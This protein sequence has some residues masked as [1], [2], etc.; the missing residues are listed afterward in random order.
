MTSQNPDL[1]PP[2]RVEPSV[3]NLEEVY[4]RCG[5]ESLD[6]LELVIEDLMDDR[7]W[8]HY[9]DSDEFRKDLVAAYQD[10]Y[11]QESE[12]I[13][14]SNAMDAALKDA[15]YWLI[16]G[17]LQPGANI[18]DTVAPK[19]TGYIGAILPAYAGRGLDAS[20]YLQFGH[21]GGEPGES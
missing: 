21:P 1:E 12:K 2:S 9:T 3:E 20:G 7:G 17:D 18:G 15:S 5:I 11:L 10:A 16:E 14:I 19:L 13:V 8:S 6:Q 4:T